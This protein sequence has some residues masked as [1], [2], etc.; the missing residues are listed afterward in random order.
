MS[1]GAISDE[2]AE[3]LEEN[4]RSSFTVFSF[5]DDVLRLAAK[6][7]REYFRRPKVGEQK[8]RVLGDSMV[9][10]TGLLAKKKV[11]TFDKDMEVIFPVYKD[12]IVLV[13]EVL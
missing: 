10:A 6:L 11:F 8:Y 3:E 2:F 12:H 9:L 7:R 4:V 1:Y 13:N 5:T